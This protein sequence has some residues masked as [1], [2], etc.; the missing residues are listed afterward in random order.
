MHRRTTI[1]VDADPRSVLPAVHDALGLS[2]D[3]TGPLPGD[4]HARLGVT[5]TPRPQ[6][7]RVTLEAE[8]TVVV[9]YFQWAFA[10]AQRWVLRRGLRHAAASVR[11]AIDGTPIPGPLRPS[12]V[13]P[14]AAFEAQQIDFL[15]SAAFAAAIASFGAALFGQNANAIADSF[16]ATDAALGTALAITRLGV[17]F[18]LVA[19]IAADR[20]GR[21][22]VILWSVVV[23][24]L[25][26]AV[27]GLA[28]SFAVFTGSQTVLRAAVNSALVIGGIAVVEEAPDGARAWA[29]S[30]LSLAA[31]AGFA[32]AVILLPL[33]DRGPDSWRIAFGLSAVALLAV[34]RIRRTLP[35]T[36]RFRRVAH[37]GRAPLRLRE[38]FDPSYGRRFLLLAAIG[39]LTNI[40]SAPS[41]QLTNRYLADVR[42]FSASGIALFRGVTNG[43][44]GLVGILLA[45][46]LAET[47]GRRPVAIASL[48]AGTLLSMAFFLS[49][50]P[51][52]WI[53]STL[54]IVAAASATLTI[55]TMDAE[56]FPTE[57]RGSSNGLMLVAYVIGS[58]TGLLAAGW[59]SGPLGGLG[60]AIALCGIAPLLAAILLVPRLPESAHRD[61]DEVSPSEV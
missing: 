29:V 28:P 4:V 33:A 18:A 5:V 2:A 22:K 9:P 44:P 32:L 41:A 50:G 38:V 23:V 42:G 61:L 53:A 51:L 52:L 48:L 20:V 59:L 36:S 57:V 46:R 21:R 39:F 43:I 16:G 6:G 14:P 55:G 12:P 10:P 30:M 35:E 49:T 56:M 27:S 15:A 37:D 17:L 26:N 58:A 8:Q 45:G 54:S 1:E 11:A 3:G 47:R 34:P 25:A 24:C 31:G 60:R 13:S 7:S 19:A 40:F